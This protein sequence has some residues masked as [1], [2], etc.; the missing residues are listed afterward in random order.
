MSGKYSIGQIRTIFLCCSL[1]SIFL[2]SCN[3]GKNTTNQLVSFPL[4]EFTIDSNSDTTIFGKQNTR[5]FIEKE[6]FEFEDGSAVL[7]SIKINLQEFYKKSDI[8]LASLSTESDNKLLETGGMLNITATSDG[9]TVKIKSDKRIVV[10]FPKQKYNYSKM[11]LFFADQNSSTD[12]SVTNWNIDTVNLVKKTL[13]IGSYAWYHPS[14]TDSTSYTFTPKQFVDTGYYWNKLDLYL[15]SCNFSVGVQKEIESNLNKTRYSTLPLWN[16][17]GIECEMSIDTNGFIK[18]PKVNSTVTQSTKTEILKFLINLP[19]LEPGKNN[20][21]EII[22]RNGL[23]FIQ[24]GNII[25]LYKTKEAYLKSFDSKYSQYEQTPIKSIDDA[26][27]EY[28][29]FSVAKLGWINCDR[30]INSEE[31]MDFIVN[32]AM[33]KNTKIK[34]V[35]KDIDGVLEAKIRDDK[36]VFSNVPLNRKVTIIGIKNSNGHFQS[37]FK[38]LSIST[39]P[40]HEL[41][42]G[43]TTLND[44]KENLEGLN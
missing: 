5:L 42:F 37:A 3:I 22:E 30:F 13:K 15:N 43:E 29:I 33:D 2:V 21:G 41:S 23:L 24:G 28:Y 10:H 20:K 16:D 38:E 26:E 4:L 18:N 9:R 27:L 6:T 14:W 39:S 31:T 32:T 34:M 17:Y 1:I 7:G 44:L 35:F 11:N 36:Y 8:I 12:T 40:L 19:Q 25:P